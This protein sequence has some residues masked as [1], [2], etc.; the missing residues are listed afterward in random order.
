MA[1]RPP[2]KWW[3]GKYYLS[4]RIIDLFPEHRIYVEPFGGAASV[5]LN[6]T[7]AD[8]ECYNDLD[9]RISRLFRVLQN[10]GEEFVTRLR[11][12][13][14]SQWEFQEAATYPA[15][16]DDL[17]KSVC[18]FIRWR[19]SFGGQGKTWSCS[20]TRVRGGMA[21][22]VNAWWTAIDMLPEIIERIRSVQILHQPALKAIQRFD[23]DEALIYCDPPYVH[24]TRSRGS[25]EVYGVEMTDAD[26]RELAAQLHE[27][28]SKVVLSGYRCD[29]YDDLY[30]SWRREEFDIAN[31]AAGGKQKA[32]QTECVWMNFDGRPKQTELFSM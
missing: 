22:D 7:P 20:T 10:S 26:H 28:R 4:A 9:V 14:Y 29:L 24:A 25:T 2:V 6:K 30:H 12:T 19:Q 11:V 27:C 17:G 32:R 16:A 5:L 8:V 1:L 31:H 23:H 15:Q 21:G 3:G 18:D 13:P